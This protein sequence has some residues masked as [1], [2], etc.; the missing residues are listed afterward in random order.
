MTTPLLKHYE[1]VVKSVDASKAPAEIGP[2]VDAVVEPYVK[3]M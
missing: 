2:A 1:S 3:K